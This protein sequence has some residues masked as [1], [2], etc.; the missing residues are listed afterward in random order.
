M[1]ITFPPNRAAALERLAAFAPFAGREYASR[2]N[3]D[4]SGHPH[5]SRLSPYLRHRMIT[6]DEVLS[7]VLR[8]HSASAAEKFIQEVCWRT[9]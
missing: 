2:R 9:Y 1:S 8:K 3:Y 4:L 7:A 5:V 6:E